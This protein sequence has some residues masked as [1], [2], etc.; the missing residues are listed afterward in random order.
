MKS[1][2]IDKIVG[3]NLCFWL[4]VETIAGVSSILSGDL[5]TFLIAFLIA[6]FGVA[7]VGTL[8][9]YVWHD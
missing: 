4:G 5:Q 3:I 7:A 6:F 8:G 2:T 1:K 9:T